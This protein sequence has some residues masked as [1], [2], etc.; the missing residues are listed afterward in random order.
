VGDKVCSGLKKIPEDYQWKAVQYMEYNAKTN[1]KASC[2]VDPSGLGKRLPTM[3]VT[4]NAKRMTGQASLI[5]APP[6]FTLQWA[7]EY[8]NSFEEVGF[9]NC[10]IERPG[11]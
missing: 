9:A 4:V 6:R 11:R 10:Y 1:L 3:I 5:I 7:E 2:I 8:S